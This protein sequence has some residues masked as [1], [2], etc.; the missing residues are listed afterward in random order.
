M[1]AALLYV[2]Q[3]NQYPIATR[4]SSARDVR[5]LQPRATSSNFA[6]IACQ[7][8]GRG[9]EGERSATLY[10]PTRT[11]L[12]L[13][14]SSSLPPTSSRPPC[15]LV[16]SLLSSFSPALAAV[17]PSMPLTHRPSRAPPAPFARTARSAKPRRGGRSR[18]KSPST[19]SFT[20][21][22]PTAA[23]RAA[24]TT[25]SSCVPV[26]W[27]ASASDGGLGHTFLRPRRRGTR[28]GAA[29]TD[30]NPHAGGA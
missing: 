15:L 23:F 8:F 20:N 28:A 1:K 22:C 18:A 6:I 7:R 10:K 27:A 2:V 29:G 25:P 11:I 19:R 9:E 3:Y 5:Q 12:R 16:P 30:S 13:A 26:A 4:H 24:R 17:M 21:I 14:S